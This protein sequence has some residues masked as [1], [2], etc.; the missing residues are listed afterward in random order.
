M[1]I[2]QFIDRL[3]DQSKH[4]MFY[5][6]FTCRCGCFVRIEFLILFFKISARILRIRYELLRIERIVSDCTLTINSGCLHYIAPFYTQESV[7]NAY[8]KVFVSI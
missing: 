8:Q 6:F 7:I 1:A 4:V 5:N 3:I 2:E